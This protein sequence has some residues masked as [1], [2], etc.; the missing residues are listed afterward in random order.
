VNKRI[1]L[2]V[3][4]CLFALPAFPQA[5]NATLTGT[6]ADAT[7]AVLPGVTITAVNTVTGVQ[8]TS[9]TNE[10]GAYTIL[11]LIP[12]AYNVT[13]DL[14]GFQK[15]T[16]TNAELANAVTVRLNFTLQIAG[17]ATGIEVSIPV[18]TLIATSSPSIGQMLSEKK[19]Q[20]LP[21]VG[22]NVLDL[23]TVLGGLDN[24]VFSG[25]G[26]LA[27]TNN[28]F[29]REGTTLAGISAR[30]VPILRDGIM[31]QDQRY[32]TG[33]NT[34]TVMNPDLIGEIRLIVA[35]V[36]A[37]LGRGNGAIQ[38][39]T[40]SG[41][42]KYAGS[43][44][45]SIQNTALNPNTWTNN[46]NQ[47][48]P[49]QPAWTTNNQGT[50]SFGGPIIKNKTF[51]FALWDMNFNRGRAVTA[52]NV[53]TPCAR[54][55]IFRYFDGWNNGNANAATVTG[56]TPTRAVVDVNGTPLNITQTP[57]GAPSQL[58]YVSVFGPVSFPAGGPNA[59]CSNAVLGSQRWDPY[60]T[61][62]DS[63]GLVKRWVDF[64]P[65]ANDYTQANTDGLNVASYR[66]LRHYRGLDNLFSVGEGTG[67]RKQINVRID[68]NLSDKHKLNFGITKETVVSDDTVAGLPG[69]WSNQ[70]FHRPLVITTG[71]VSTLTPS[72]V[73]EAK[74]GYRG[75][76]TNVIAPWDLSENLEGINTFLGPLKSVNGFLSLPDI[77]GSLV[78]C[79]PLTG[80]RPPGNCLGGNATGANLTATARDKTP[81]WTYG[82]SLSWT[83]GTHTMKFGGEI[84]FNSSTSTGS[85]PGNAFFTNSKSPIVLVGGST[86]FAAIAQ[87][88]TTSISNGNPAMAG[89][90]TNDA[91]RARNLLTF[92]SGS[93][94]S[95]NNTYFLTDP[96]ATSFS[97]YRNSA[98]ITNTIKQREFDF[99]FKDDYKIRRDLTLNLGVRWEWYGV[100]YAASGLTVSPVQDNG[101]SAFG[102]SGRDFTGWM[103]PGK[104]GDNT[105]LQFVGPGSPNP[106]KSVYQN[107]W[108]N[109]G[110]A[111]GFAWQ[112]PWLG[113][114]KTTLRGGYQI[115]YQGGGRF[116]TLEG[117]L[118][119]PPGK[120][121]PGTY[122]G[123]STNPYLSLANSSLATPTPL[124]VGTAPMSPIRIDDRNTSITFFDPNYSSPYVQN[125][126]LSLTRAMRRNLTL[127]VRYVGTLARRQ[128]SSVNLNT[129]NFLYNGLLDALNSVR[130]GGESAL[131]DQMFNGINLCASGCTT[132]VT[133]G[134][135][136]STVGGVLQT[137]ALQ[138]RSNTTFQ[139]NLANGN[140]S[141]IA[142]S[143]N[144]L[145]YQKVGCPSATGQNCNLPDVLSTVRGSVLRV[146]NFPEN[147]ITTNPQFSTLTYFN[148]VGNNN[149]HSLQAEVTLRPTHGFSATAN[150]TWS[151][152]LGLPGAFTNPV[153]R[154][155]DYSIVNTNHPH[156]LRTNGSVELPIGPNKLLM[157]NTTG[158]LARAIEKWQVGFIYTLQSGA[159]QSI[160]TNSMLYNNGV[161]DVVNAALLHELLDQAHVR[162]GTVAGGGQLE[163]RYFEPDQW[164]KTA[165]PQCASVTALQGLSGTGGVARCTLQALAKVVPAGTA[166]SV[167]TARDAAGN[168]TQY[169]LIVLQNPQP[170]KQGNLGRNVLRDLPVYRWDGN[171]SKT[172]RLT[173][174][175]SLAFRADVT[176]ILNHPQPNAPSLTINS[177]NS[178]TPWGQI[179]GK[180]GGTRTVQ[181]QLRLNF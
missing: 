126:T 136:G 101:N 88:G 73:N 140:Y 80:A 37:E 2:V 117:P 178:A 159:W 57:T 133:Y 15:Q 83:K 158:P 174:T 17:G 8:S 97:D 86:A 6:V 160:T 138:M 40:R 10:A 72:L 106:G 45:W 116:N 111:V 43:A 143:L 109:V 141:A 121:Y 115:T 118:S 147:F 157:G 135:V 20:D 112:V 181:G 122:G 146:N 93:L 168:P 125:L 52:V 151:K 13:A 18:D 75:N 7:G 94:A 63:T 103:T 100:P 173:E 62:V 4:L 16:N 42:N 110:P 153:D 11:G 169:G 38:I 179:S 74:F 107:S 84:R 124:P 68:H 29:G 24:Y 66:F 85:S 95:V 61:A 12:G 79:N 77:G 134:A 49:T 139:A 123:D 96:K 177:A 144:T 175:K 102:Y 154:H 87:N 22:N 164:V 60:R 130:T 19:V 148:N 69:T 58:Q 165:D 35:P 163:G 105:T 127:D 171:L 119:N 129:A 53:L 30:D 81:S 39:S 150:Y 48:R 70:N 59:D 65:A 78:L 137:A 82:D 50:V 28:A 41:T 92:L 172:F 46:R 91:T 149:Y 113:K 56:A 1:C 120:T 108:N 3:V 180:G 44:V 55:G 176:N 170:G 166:G 31:V 64:M 5:N 161:P 145:N 25:T 167:V 32:T 89:L 36:D 155:Q 67:D 128:F 33:I 14:T 90:Q 156:I 104:R 131:L 23:L 99:F 27:G 21:V 34:A 142:S 26:G 76:G 51:F 47:P 54:N 114:D 132:G 152:N 9:I 71:F 162:W 98:L